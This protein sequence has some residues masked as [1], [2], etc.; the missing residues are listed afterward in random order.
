MPDMVQYDVFCNIC[1]AR[2]LEQDPAV[3]WIYGDGVW[4]CADESLCAD[5][6]AMAALETETSQQREGS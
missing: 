3:T 1:G 6:R 2:Y 5:R 4:E